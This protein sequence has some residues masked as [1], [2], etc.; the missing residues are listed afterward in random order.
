VCGDGDCDVTEENT[1]TADCIHI[2][3]GCTDGIATNFNPDANQ[4]D[5]S[6]KY[7]LG[8]MD[9]AAYNYNPLATKSDG[10]CIAGLKDRSSCQSNTECGS[11]NCN[12][13][14]Y[15]TCQPKLSSQSQC[16]E[17]SQCQS[18]KCGQCRTVLIWTYCFCE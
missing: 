13:T 4:D 8:C 6:C 11:G 7:V 12:G 18:G 10:S 1:C 15:K 14:V 3:P 5:G 2:T 16:K 17:N 9:R